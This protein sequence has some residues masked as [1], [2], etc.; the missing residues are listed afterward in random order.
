MTHL[1]VRHKG[2]V[3]ALAV[4][5]L[6]PTMASSAPGDLDQSFSGNGK[7]THDV[8]DTDNLATGIAV[9]PDG[10][11]VTA[12]SYRDETDFDISLA[13]FGESGV[14][15]PDFGTDASFT[16]ELAAHPEANEEVDD[17]IRQGQKIVVV[18]YVTLSENDDDAYIIRRMANGT[19]DPNFGEGGETVSGMPGWDEYSAVT[20]QED[21][22]L[23][24]AGQLCNPNCDFL[25]A[26]FNQDGTL[27]TDS[28]DDPGTHFST[29]GWTTTDFGGEVDLAGELT[30]LPS[31][32][33]VV[34]GRTDEDNDDRNWAV[35]LYKANGQ[36]DQNFSGDGMKKT[37]LGM[38]DSASAVA[39][40]GNSIVV[41]GSTQTTGDVPKFNWALVAYTF[42]G[43]LDGDFAGD[44]KRVIDH[45]G[46]FD[47][48]ADMTRQPDGKLLVAGSAGTSPNVRFAIARLSPDGKLDKNFG[49]SGIKRFAVGGSSSPRAITMDD[50][51]RIVV[52]GSVL[53]DVNNFDVAVARL[54]SGLAP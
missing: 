51:K 19:P 13:R 14:P 41:G 49:T 46:E 5:L 34:V 1:T 23:V 4:L 48:I 32:K 28:D 17:A 9:F 37:D 35:A 6:L 47:G 42:A 40:I 43:Q 3:A 11:I 26:R 52:G 8:D 39:V 20:R 50:S 44:G 18:G 7:L 16:F 38:S 24:V 27:D 31:G 53:A 10:A 22:K 36:P 25:V 2:Q 33:I 21:G 45:G 30:I 15:D 29:D 54:K 12:G